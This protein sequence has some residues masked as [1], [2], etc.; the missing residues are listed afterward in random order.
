MH[1]LHDNSADDKAYGLNDGLRGL[2]SG[3]NT[4]HVHK[5]VTLGQLLCANIKMQSGLHGVER[6]ME[7]QTQEVARA[8]LAYDGMR[9]L[10]MPVAGCNRRCKYLTCF[11]RRLFVAC[12]SQ[13]AFGG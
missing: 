12:A 9:A 13:A 8:D 5:T 6:V 3:T 2:S 7:E 4:L 10:T 1:A 11:S